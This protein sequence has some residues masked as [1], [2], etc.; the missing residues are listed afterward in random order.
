MVVNTATSSGVDGTGV[1]KELVLEGCKG[2]GWLA[3]NGV[4]RGYGNMNAAV[5]GD[6]CWLMVSKD[7]KERW[8][9]SWHVGVGHV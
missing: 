2:E 8:L 4:N 7:L 1:G 6:G 9:R 3:C 5:N